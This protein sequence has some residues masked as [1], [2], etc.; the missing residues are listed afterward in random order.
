MFEWRL[1]ESVAISRLKESA[2]FLGAS[3]RAIRFS[4]V[5]CFTSATVA[6]AVLTGVT[7]DLGIVWLLIF[8]VFSTA[9]A[10]VIN[11]LSDSELDRSAG[12]LRNPVSTGELSVGRTI[13][14]AFSFLVVSF[15]ALF[16]LSLQTWLLGLVV[17]FL[18]FTYSWIIRAKARPM[19]DITYHGSCPAILA[20]MGYTQY[21]PFNVTCFLLASMAFLLSAVSQI[22]QETRDYETDKKML[23][24]TATLLGKRM[25]LIL[26][27]AF[28]AS[29]FVIFIPLLFYG[30]ISP[31]ILL[32]SPL[33]Y[34]IIAPVIGAIRNEEYTDNMLREIREKRLILIALSI[35]ALILG[36]I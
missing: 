31:K 19:L 2:K 14:L 20:I 6:G 3:Y 30:M 17:V 18:Y 22:L 24:T 13:S 23:K 7:I 25:S 11:D 26:C 33:A 8:S 10:F 34:F 1:A 16:F 21:R 28:C 12:V 35:V 4:S 32:L 29:A 9:F 36:G 15:A 27:L 5:L